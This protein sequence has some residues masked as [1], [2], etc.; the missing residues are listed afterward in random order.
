MLRPSPTRSQIIGQTERGSILPA[1]FKLM[2]NCSY[3]KTLLAKDKHLTIKYCSEESALDSVEDPPYIKVNQI[4]EDLYEVTMKKKRVI[5]NLPIQ[6]GFFVYGYSQAP[7]VTFLLRLTCLN[8]L[9]SLSR[10]GK[11]AVR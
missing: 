4:D 2:G 1:V 5:W 7:Y 6:I 3:G 8:N 11:S 9:P 10:S